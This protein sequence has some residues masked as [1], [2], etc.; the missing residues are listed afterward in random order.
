MDCNDGGNNLLEV[1]MTNILE[2]LVYIR[3]CV[4]LFYVNYRT[5]YSQ[6]CMRWV[7]LRSSFYWQLNRLRGIK[8][9]VLGEQLARDRH[10]TQIV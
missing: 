10:L 6:H 1:I 4:N 3:H 8:Y 5:Y 7:Q 9:L 2:N